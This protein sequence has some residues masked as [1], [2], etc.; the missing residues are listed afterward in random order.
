MMII[1][2]TQHRRISATGAAIA[3]MMTVRGIPRDCEVVKRTVSASVTLE[4]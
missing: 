1:H 4:F 3:G 2:A